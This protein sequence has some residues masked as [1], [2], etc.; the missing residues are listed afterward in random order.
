MWHHRVEINYSYL[1]TRVMRASLCYTLYNRDVA[2]T[3]S[4]L[5]V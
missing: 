4:L 1:H 5:T 2:R 3:V